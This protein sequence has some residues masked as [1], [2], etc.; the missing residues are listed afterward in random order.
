[1]N[2]DNYIT[3]ITFIGKKSYFRVWKSKYEC[4]PTIMGLVEILEDDIEITYD[5]EDVNEDD[6]DIN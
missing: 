4:R 2:K 1:M 3:V 5:S 6:K